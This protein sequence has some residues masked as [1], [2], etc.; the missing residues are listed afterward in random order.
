MGK[1]ETGHGLPRRF[2]RKKSRNPASTTTRLRLRQVRKKFSHERLQGSLAWGGGTLERRG[3]RELIALL[4]RTLRGRP[5]ERRVQ[6]GAWGRKGVLILYFSKD[7]E[8]GKKRKR[9]LPLFLAED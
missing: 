2:S 5:A 1:E 6:R 8:K 4:K 3:G 9:V 7:T